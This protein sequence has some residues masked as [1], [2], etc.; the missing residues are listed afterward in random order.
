MVYERLCNGKLYVLGDLQRTH[1][2][3]YLMDTNRV[4]CLPHKTIQTKYKP[5]PELRAFRERK[6]VV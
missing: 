4:L 5:R 6:E 3:M 2:W 1:G